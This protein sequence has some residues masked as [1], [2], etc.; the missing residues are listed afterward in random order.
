MFEQHDIDELNS[1]IE[2]WNKRDKSDL[3][4]EMDALNIKHSKYSPNKVPLRRAVKDRLR[5]S[6]GLINK[7][8]YSMPRSAVFLHKGV[9][10]GHGKNNPREAKEWYE[11]VVDRNLPDLAEI[12]ANG[13]GNMII[14]ALKIR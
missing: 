3:L 10:R 8:S 5:K 9:S 2:Q 13:N 1:D 12:V 4:S 11:P 14:N 7:I 6:R